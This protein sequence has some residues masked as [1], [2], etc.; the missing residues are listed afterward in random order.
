MACCLNYMA[1]YLHVCLA[2]YTSGILLY[3][4]LDSLSG[5]LDYLSNMSKCL[6]VFF[7]FFFFGD[8]KRNINTLWLFIVSVGE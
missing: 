1:D 8:L 7:L 2:V 4:V 3:V 6:D 5:C